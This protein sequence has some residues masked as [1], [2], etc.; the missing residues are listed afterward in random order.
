MGLNLPWEY[1]RYP[2]Q[3]DDVARVDSRYHD[4]NGKVACSNIGRCGRNDKGDDCKVKGYRD[5]EIS[6]SSSIGMPG[7]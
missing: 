1:V 5:V 6:F 4:H 7:I 2:P 3:A